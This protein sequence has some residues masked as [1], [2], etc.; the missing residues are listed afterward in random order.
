MAVQLS[1]HC[2]D[3]GAERAANSGV[4]A[5]CETPS[6]PQCCGDEL[7]YF[8]RTRELQG[9]TASSSSFLVTA[10]TPGRG[11]FTYS[12]CP[13][14]PAR[15]SLFFV[16]LCESASVNRTWRQRSPEIWRRKDGESGWDPS[17]SFG[18]GVPCSHAPSASAMTRS[19][20]GHCLTHTLK[21]RFQLRAHKVPT[22]ALTREK[23]SPSTSNSAPA[24]RPRA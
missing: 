18:Q 7:T 21:R 13:I 9:R 4:F 15:V 1:D 23:A 12:S 11:E 17:I 16:S 20:P 22:G 2:F 3:G 24:I 10:N 19:C 5:A 14:S 8:T 6:K